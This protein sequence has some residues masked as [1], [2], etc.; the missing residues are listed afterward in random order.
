MRDHPTPA[1]DV[2]ERLISAAGKREAPPAQAYE[3]ALA[4]ATRSWQT[5]VRRGRWRV[6]STLAACVALA[7]IGA[8]VALRSIDSPTAPPQAIANVSRMIGDVR[9]RT[10][11]YPWRTLQ[12]AAA[13]PAGA[14]VRVETASAAAL[15]M[16]AVSVRIA[17][18][19]EIILESP[20]RLRL[21][22][23]KVYVD[24]GGGESMG[25]MLVVTDAL[26]VSDVGT[27]FEVQE[28]DG[29][30]RV[31]VREGAVLLEHGGVRRRGAAGDQI[32]LD[33]DGV[34][35]LSTFSPNDRDWRWVESLATAP[36]IDNQPLTVL[37]AW[38]ARETG[39]PV[40]Y[41]TPAIERK[42]TATIL[43]GSIRNL[44]PLVALSVMLATTDL[45]HEVWPDGTIMIK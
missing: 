7:T 42:A 10:E 4:A 5:Q 26:S 43:H 9:V 45:R 18:G 11:A 25:A 32:H 2:L 36:D 39:A 41:A 17:G 21:R 33:R 24:T 22:Q 40:R 16:G 12:D 27:Q 20:S 34:V 13:L 15:Q 6:A 19:A 44:E 3:R 28:R 31:R 8:V 35:R 23:G 30:V 37:L 29:A 14:V 38:V 1:T